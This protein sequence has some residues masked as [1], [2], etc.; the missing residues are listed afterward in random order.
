M[1]L[2]LLPSS[3][4]YAYKLNCERGGMKGKEPLLDETSLQLEV[5]QIEGES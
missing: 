4:L 2:A 3:D 5:E 1:E